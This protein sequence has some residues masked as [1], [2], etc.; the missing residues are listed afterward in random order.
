M[1]FFSDIIDAIKWSVSDVKTALISIVIMV[2]PLVNILF[3]GYTLRIPR[4]AWSF[5]ELPPWEDWL[6]ALADGLRVLAVIV[7]WAILLYIPLAI[8]FF[9]LPSFF[10][11]FLALPLFIAGLWLFPGFFLQLAETHL[12]RSAF[13]FQPLLSK[14]S[15]ATYIIALLQAIVLSALI[16][17]PTALLAW[18]TQ[19]L[20]ILQILIYVPTMYIITISS[21]Y[22]LAKGWRPD[23]T[24]RERY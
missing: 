7:I 16:G 8:L 6:H 1:P 17:I 22:L 12:I 4:S 11:P 2:I 24:T 9:L 20:Y 13:W 19:D 5:D 21:Y 18:L 3:S 15:R 14:C 10:L 23:M